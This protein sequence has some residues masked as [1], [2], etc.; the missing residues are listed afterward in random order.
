[1]HFILFNPKLDKILP[2]Y[3]YSE[4][5]D[6]RRRGLYKKAL[7]TPQKIARIQIGKVTGSAIRFETNGN[8]DIM[9]LRS[10]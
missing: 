3:S 10:N 2:E 6:K 5:P 9:V 8:S 4:L 7:K 1:M